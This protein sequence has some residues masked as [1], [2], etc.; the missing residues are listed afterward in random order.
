[1]ILQ[2][3]FLDWTPC[4]SQ[5]WAGFLFPRIAL[6][7]HDRLS[8]DTNVLKNAVTINISMA[9]RW[10]VQILGGVTYQFVLNWRLSLLMIAVIPV[11]SISAK[12]YGQ[13]LRKLARKTQDALAEATDVASESIGNVRTVRGFAR[14]G[15][16]KQLYGAAVEESYRY[17]AKVSKGYGMFIGFISTVGGGSLISI[18]Y[19]GGMMVVDGDMTP[20]VLTSYLL[21]CITISGSLA[22]FAGV[23]SQFMSAA[24]AN[25]RVFQL[26]DRKPATD[27][28]A[29]AST[30]ANA[31][32][33]DGND[34]NGNDD[35]NGDGGDR[36]VRSGG[37]CGSSARGLCRANPRRR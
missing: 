22:G 10:A 21:Y 35:R 17:G 7:I 3:T 11:M 32:K 4:F 5:Q 20:G 23:A 30:F 18:L 25:E 27:L 37:F 31:K 8:A 14:E 15:R 24:G 19:Y 16:Q 28:E 6:Q 9:L 33:E 2:S 13:Y 26:L 34:G 29:G 36:P 12:C 1:M